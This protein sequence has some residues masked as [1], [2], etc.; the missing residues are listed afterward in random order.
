M[1]NKLVFVRE[2]ISL[3]LFGQEE[4]CPYPALP[5]WLNFQLYWGINVLE[6]NMTFPHLT[7]AR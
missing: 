2:S 7:L 6:E 3:I 5:Q 4:L 1:F